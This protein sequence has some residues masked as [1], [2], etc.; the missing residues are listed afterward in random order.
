MRRTDPY[1]RPLFNRTLREPIAAAV[2]ALIN[3]GR[4]NEGLGL[5]EEKPLP[6]E[7][8]AVDSIIAD[9]GAYM[10]AMYKP[11]DYLRAGNTKTHGVVR[12]EVIIR[13]DIPAHLRRGI[14]AEPRTY[15]AWVR[16]SGP[17]PDS[18]PDIEDVGFS[19][20]AIKMMGVPGPKLLDDERFTQDLIA[21]STPTFVTPNIIENAK[22]Q[23]QSN[24][25][26]TPI[27]YF[28]RPGDTHIL[29]FIMQGLWNETK[30]SPLESQYWSCVPYLLG[31]GQAMMY[32][33]RPKVWT[34]TPIPNLPF[35]PPDHYLRD[36]LAATLAERDAD[37]DILVQVQTDPHLMPIENAGV[38]WPERLSPWVPVATLRLP[39]QNPSWRAQFAFAHTLRYNP[40]HCIP[41]HRP[42]GNQGRARKRMYSEL[43]TL[44]QIQNRTPHREP[45]GDEVL[46]SASESDACDGAERWEEQNAVTVFAAVKPQ[47]VAE[48]KRELDRIGAA[49]RTTGAPFS[50]SSRIHYARF[51]F[52]PDDLDPAL[53]YAGPALMYL[54]DFDGTRDRHLSEIADIGAAIFDTLS[55]FLVDAIPSTA[56]GRRQWLESHVIPDATA[57]VNTV[58]RT[59]ARI[60]CEAR[61]RREIEAFLDRTPVR[62][63]TPEELRRRIQDFVRSE[64]S[65]QWALKPVDDKP[66]RLRR[67]LA[68]IAI[69]AL[70]VPAALVALPVLVV[71]ALAVRWHEKT[72]AGE[73][74]RPEPVHVAQLASVEDTTLQNQFSALSFRKPAW[75]RLATASV[76]LCLAR[77]VVRYFFDRGSLAGVKTIHFARWTFIDGKRRM[78]FTS[79][80][81]GSLENYMGDFIDI[82]AWGLNAVFSNGPHYPRTR[83]LILDG[84]W[85]EAAFKR[86]IRNRQIPTQVWYCAYP[87]LSAVQIAD[88]ARLREGLFRPQ[89]ERKTKD[90]LRLLRR[91]WGRPRAEPIRL[92]REDMQGLLVRGHS[93]HP[94]ACFILLTFGEG[95]AGSTAAK[96][97]LQILLDDGSVMMDGSA[98][99][100]DFYAHV[101]FTHE[102][103]RRLNYPAE[104]LAGFSDEFRFGMV[105]PHRR[106]ILGDDGPSSPDTW[107]WGG[108]GEPLHGVL[109]LYARD[110]AQLAIL[111]ERYRSSLQ[112]HGIAER[113]LETTWLADKKEHF[114][115]HD[116]ITTPIVEGLGREAEAG[117]SI[118][119][120]EFF[121]GYQNE[122]GR[123]TPSPLVHR[124]LDPGGFLKLDAQGSGMA[125]FGR[126]GSYLVFRQLDQDVHGFWSFI[127]QAA[128]NL[129]GDPRRREWIAAKMVGRWPSGAPLTLAPDAD[130]PKLANADDFA[131][132]RTDARGAKCPIGAHIRRTNPRDSLDPRPG[133]LESLAVNRRHRLL[134]RGRTYGDP[135]VPGLNPG[136]IV[137]R[138]NDGKRRGLHF[139][140][141]N[142]NIARQFEFV[143]A[144]WANNPQFGGLYDD[145][146]PLIGR[147]GRF[148]DGDPGAA[149]A[150]FTIPDDAGRTRICGLPNFVTTRGGAYFFM[151]GMSALRYLAHTP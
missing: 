78:L 83:W 130:D 79:N 20:I 4:P 81:D 146:D 30:T 74:P 24:L 92:E 37:F 52:I 95:Q 117:L 109:A 97:W 147:R 91:D 55:P 6:G 67:S 70:A 19:S 100:S 149:A 34:R 11:G 35:R 58:G 14:F 144:S 61:L 42:L 116:G 63:E 69:L 123:C 86:H 135:L 108:P 47:S 148:A 18:P 99:R 113:T 85:N 110:D 101:A 44:R 16:F 80:Y 29:D 94:A 10:R 8:A 150:N 127:D 72:E 48:L 125:D 71:W 88:N 33:V 105:T 62:S 115:F 64:P 90:W 133:S 53:G 15:K 66:W 56:A 104:A 112:R 5:A 27:L 32:S 141:L 75:L 21:V 12:G 151:P 143:Q 129:D 98:D 46:E 136:G 124:S 22:L 89:S 137:A 76:F 23:K 122:Y 51:V 9:M 142:A 17:G 45:T 120:G 25:R 40:W 121:L 87:N 132:H 111:R 96:R 7:E 39:R 128:R 119:P 57:Y 60:R 77:P 38:R 2:Q 134:R 50:A 102:G 54:A 93:R 118:K 1:Y 49:V 59:V 106:R 43:S 28:L 68:R 31:E 26:R 138:G 41:E 114:G 82:V 131:Y 126:N 13:E 145:V 73:P 107:E 84:A 65:L 3:R 36:A 139:I 140:C 103:L